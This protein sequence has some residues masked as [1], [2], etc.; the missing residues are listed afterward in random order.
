[1]YGD[2][3]FDFVLAAAFFYVSL[4]CP[5]NTVGSVTNAIDGV[6]G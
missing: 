6:H 3:F 1:M 2:S 4:F 5:V